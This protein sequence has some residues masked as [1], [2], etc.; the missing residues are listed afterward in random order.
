MGIGEREHNEFKE[1]LRR[2]DSTIFRVCLVFTNRNPENVRDMY[3]DIVCSLWENWPRFRGECKENTWVYR[4]AFNI[5]VSQVRRR[6]ISPMFTTLDDETYSN[7][8]EESRNELIER[9][10]ELIDRLTDE[11]KRIVLLYIDRLTAREIGATLG[12]TEA[13]VKHRIGRIKDKLITLNKETD[14]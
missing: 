12:L 6:S 4:I 8:A 11:E 13:A 2:C 9:L 10:Y 3:Q 1:M 14:E 7:L 5:A